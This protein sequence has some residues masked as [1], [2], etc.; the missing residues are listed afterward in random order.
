[1]SSSDRT[2]INAFKEIGTMADRINLTRTIVD[3]ANRLFKEVHDGK[4]L[5]GHSTDASASACLYIA[6]RWVPSKESSS[7]ESIIMLILNF[8]NG[9]FLFVCKDKKEF[10]ELSKRFVPSARLEKKKLEDVSN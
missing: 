6:C 7:K 4:N 3:R 2:L 5:K 9:I 8:F 1:M 10:R